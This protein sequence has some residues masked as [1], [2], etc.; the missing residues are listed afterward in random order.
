MSC[1]DGGYT[2]SVKLYKDRDNAV[3]IIPYSD[4][5]TLENYDMTD[6]T[7]VTA[8]ADATDSTTVGDAIAGDS[9][10]DPL[11]VYWDNNN[12]DTQWRIYAK[13]GLFDSIVAGEYTLRI[14][15]YDPDNVNGLVLPDTDSALLITIVDL[16]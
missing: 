2:V 10:I 16:P 1:D 3:G 7:R 4:I 13:V 5:T 12:A 14:T 15:I 8:H 9:A 11:K 6:V